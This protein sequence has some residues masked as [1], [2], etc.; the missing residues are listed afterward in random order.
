MKKEKRLLDIIATKI[1][2]CM[3]YAISISNR[4]ISLQ[5]KFIKSTFV[6][7]KKF[8]YIPKLNPENN[9]IE[10][11]KGCVRIVLTF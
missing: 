6:Q 8:G 10:M 11:D 4:D 1:D 5:G 2:L 9:W 7:L 3:F